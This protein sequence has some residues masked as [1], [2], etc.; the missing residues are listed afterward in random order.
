MID[1]GSG[2]GTPVR[3][4]VGAFEAVT[5]R[6]LPSVEAPARPGDAAHRASVLGAG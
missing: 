2:T 5:G 6:P 1:L 3:E 4:L